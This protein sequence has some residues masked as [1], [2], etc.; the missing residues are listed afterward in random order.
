VGCDGS[1]AQGPLA[2]LPVSETLR[3]PVGGPVDIIRDEHGIPHIYASSVADATYAQGYVMAQDRL[4]QMDL[5]RHY[6]SGTLAEL[7][8][9]LDESFIDRDIAMRAHHMRKT[10]EEVWAALRASPL[11]DDRQTV[12]ALQSFAAGVNAALRELQSGQRRLPGAFAL[13]YDPAAAA[14]W[15]EI[16]S[17]V[18]AR[19]QAF[20]LSYD[21]DA[22][23][24]R[25]QAEAAAFRVFDQAVDPRL[26][27]RRGLASDLFRPTPL[28]PAAIL[29]DASSPSCGAQT[30]RPMSITAQAAP[31]RTV[32][33][34]RGLQ[35]AIEGVGR[36]RRLHEERG[37]NNW[38]VSGA[39]AKGGHPLLANDTHLSLDNPPVFY[40]CHLRVKDKGKGA[41]DVDLMGV[42]FPGLPGVVLGTN[43]HLSWGST[44][45]YADVTDVY[46][47]RVLSCDGSPC[48]EFRDPKDKDAQPRQ[49]KLVPRVEKI[50]VGR[51]GKV[52][53]THEVTLWDVPH[54][55][56][57]LP[58][59][60]AG[61]QVPRPAPVSLS[62]RYTGHRPTFELRAILNLNRARSVSEGI[63]ALERDFS[64]GSQNWV[65][66]DRGG[67]I[68]WTSHVAL[69]ARPAGARPFVIQPGDG[70]AEWLPQDVPAEKQPRALDPACGLL[71][72]A[73]NDPLGATRDG[74]PLPEVYHGWDYD[75][76]AR[77]GRITERLRT[78]GPIT[79]EKMAEIQA[80]HRSF[81][82]GKLGP[83]LLDTAT[84]L[85]EEIAQPGKHPDLAQAAM[86]LK[87]AGKGPALLDAAISKLRAWRLSTPAGL[88]QD[89]EAS[90]A[91]VQESIAASIFNAW[92]AEL[93]LRTLEDEWAA[94]DAAYAPQGIKVP[95][96]HSG[97]QRKLL[98]T[99]ALQP[100]QLTVG[101][102]PGGDSLLFDDLSTPARTETRREIAGLSLAAA[103]QTLAGHLGEDPAGWQWGRLHRLILD[104]LLPV[105]DLRLPHPKDPHFPQGLPRHGDVFSVD[106]SS[107][108][109]RRGAARPGS[110]FTY[111]HGAA[112]RFVAEMA[113]D[114]VRA[115]N[116]LPGGQVFDPDS[117]H[118]ADQLA[119]WRR[120]QAIALP[121][122]EADVAASAGREAARGIAPRVQ[123]LPAGT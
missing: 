103:L 91:E 28:D 69:P 56:P 36:P 92:L 35:P 6:A 22:E 46:E 57:I 20:E 19:L 42:Q 118:Y 114:G 119:L 94:I 15:T 87:A 25:T 51:F 32:Y 90:P 117:P 82:G 17:L 77:A 71:V 29:P 54:H 105:A 97:F 111:G 37:S 96:P 60:G 85:K 50:G 89:Y 34:L 59:I 16:D 121:L 83:L 23:I 2:D 81:L 73:N 93:H 7:F 100:G 8:G 18:L 62:V 70:S 12:L 72:T 38:I 43:G 33:D 122:R 106:A 95:R 113:P 61:H 74:A 14:P 26:R 11:E 116:V 86:N 40:L 78:E 108:G 79:P 13:A 39:R 47:E 115:W 48:V 52:A 41:E 1:Q 84:A 110:D 75:V 99:A 53:R 10:A 5:L 21:A 102:Q 67:H 80:D 76:G 63:A 24:A 68:G 112:I 101:R 109:L 45:T 123:I 4:V 27:S 49:I 88:E 104:P 58:Q 64:V 44:V 98:V 31:A 9:A 65:L 107:Y 120:N 30:P 55:G 66:A 3:G